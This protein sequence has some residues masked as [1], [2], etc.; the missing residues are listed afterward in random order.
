MADD[1]KFD[2]IRKLEPISR[3]LRALAIPPPETLIP[4]PKEI[5]EDIGMKTLEDVLPPIK[6]K[7]RDKLF[8]RLNK[9]K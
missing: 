4:T 7:I 2:N 3:A 5:M 1:D 6:E 9:R 8:R